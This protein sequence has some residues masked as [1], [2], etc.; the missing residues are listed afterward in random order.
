[1][2]NK[3]R[4]RKRYRRTR[5]APLVRPT[6]GVSKAFRA[7]VESIAGPH[8]TPLVFAAFEGEVLPG[9]PEE[10]HGLE[11]RLVDLARR[12]LAGEV[13]LEIV[14]EVHEN[15]NYLLWSMAEARR[16]SSRLRATD[17]RDVLV[18]VYGG[19]EARIRTPYMVPR[20]SK[21]EEKP[22]KQRGRGG[23]G[24]FPL[25]AALGF[26]CNRASPGVALAAARNS[27][28]L[29]SF[30]EATG[31]LKSQ[32]LDLDPD[33]VR[34]LTMKVGDAGLSFREIDK[35]IDESVFAGK[36]V[37]I[38]PDGGR[39]RLRFDKPGRRRKSGFHG[40]ETPWREPKVFAAYTVD[41]Q[42]N[43][44]SDELPVYEGT[45]APWKDAIT[46]AARTL[47]RYGIQ[48]AKSIVIAADG[49]DNIWRETD[50]LIELSGIDPS[51]VTRLVDFT[52]AVG[53]L[54][55]AAKLS[56]R[57]DTEQQR[58]QWVKKQARRLKRGRVELVVKDME[59]LPT[60]NDEATAKLRT[61]CEY[62]RSRKELLRYDE[63][64]RQGLPIGTGAVESAIRRI[65]N[66]RL[67]APG[68]FWTPKNAERMLYLR[69]RA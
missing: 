20:R 13:L 43:K 9:T 69:C 14:R 19:A 50:R 49:S 23:A 53:H 44:I 4:T 28:L 25:L 54:N 30:G 10:F 22:R 61:E 6:V 2:S 67:K 60:S 68:T 1:M 12:K 57:F 37:V 51:K 35:P 31:T 21:H 17:D 29:A 55:D 16:R 26:L 27:A 41:E 47:R 59:D 3:R 66:L 56:V 36:R 8:L 34:T 62:F 38:A 52:H 58:K 33:S 40:Y 24:L 7:R 46:I 48:H 18:R 15:E 42:G 5:S 64:R 65:V 32:G 45:L 39:L 63:F 11:Q